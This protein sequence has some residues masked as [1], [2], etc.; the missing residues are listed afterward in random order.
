MSL[1]R[2]AVSGSIFLSISSII[3]IVIGFL[4][5]IALARLL[6]PEIFGIVSLAAFL[7]DFVQRPRLFGLNLALIHRKDAGENTIS[8]H[9][10]LQISFTVSVIVLSFLVSPLLLLKY[11]KNVVF[12]FMAL[13]AFALF[14]NEGLNSTQYTLM[15]KELRYKAVSIVNLISLTVAFLIAIVF[16]HF[17]F[18]IVSL[19]LFRGLQ[20]LIP[21]ISYWIINPWRFRF[22]KLKFDKEIAKW[23]VRQKGVF[24]WIIGV[25]GFLLLTFNDF[26]I[27]TFAG[28]TLLGFYSM[29]FNIARMPLGP[30]TNIIQVAFPMYSKIQDDG[31][32]LSNA[33]DIVT[34]FLIR[35][36]FLIAL[37]LFT[38]AREAVLVLMGPKW[39][40]SILLIQLLV[41][42]SFGRPLYDAIGS[43]FMALG[44]VKEYSRVSIVQGVLMLVVAPVVVYFFKAEGA[45][46]FV[47][48]IV[49]VGV[50]LLQIVLRR[51]FYINFKKIYLNPSISTLPGFLAYLFFELFGYRLELSNV[52]VLIIKIVLF[53]GIYLLTLYLLEG[54][55]LLNK[56]R[57]LK[58]LY[59]KK[60][61]VDE[62]Y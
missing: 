47:S 2:K 9:F 55:D 22:S 42:Y 39:E 58:S 37:L 28:I 24:I 27:G 3:L 16:A 8:T 10:I 62:K 61:V 60:P 1:A 54:K 59:L 7:F 38:C 15:E 57:M 56:F 53:G 32:K 29:A 41:L 34:G 52:L 30:L 33:F 44:K 14:D 5:N 48:L 50:V 35:T 4:G 19:I 43:I 45:A 36:G 17:R 20:N 40:G 49:V 46:I 26:L 12:A 51:E 25:M 31:E 23:F 11:D 21:C 18:G 13:A 6:A